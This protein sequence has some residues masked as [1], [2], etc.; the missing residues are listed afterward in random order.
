M[1]LNRRVFVMQDPVV[2]N[3][4][5]LLVVKHYKSGVNLECGQI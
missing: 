2:Q 1:Y 3:L 4:T 5:K